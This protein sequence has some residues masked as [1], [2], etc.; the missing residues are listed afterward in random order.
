MASFTLFKFI[1]I[2]VFIIS[3]AAGLFM[4]Y[5]YV[6][7]QRKVLVYPTPENIDSIQYKDATGTCFAV[8]N[9]QVKCPK[10]ES[11]ISKIPA[12]N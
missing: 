7:T 11:L 1:N 3:L 12:Q 4:I 2:P 9:E 5:V 10:D 6:P 8:K